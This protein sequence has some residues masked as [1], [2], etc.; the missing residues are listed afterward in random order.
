VLMPLAWRFL[1]ESR[2][3]A[4][5][6]DV[7]GVMTASLG[8]LGIVLGLVRGPDGWTSP[9]VVASLLAGVAILGCFVWWE[10][11]T[12][13][14][15]LPLR[16]FRRRG[17]AA[18]NVS[19]LFFS[20]GMFGSIFFLSQF[21]QTVQG[22]S[23]LGA[24]L[25]ILPWTMAP[26]L[27]A[28]VVGQLAERWGGKLL[29]GVGLALQS[30]ALV[31][32]AA[33]TTP[34]TSYLAFVAPFVVAGVG[35]TLFFVPIASLALGSVPAELEGVASGT[36]AAFRE[37]GGVLGIAVLGAV[38]SSSG[39]YGSRLDYVHGLKPAILVGAT[40]VLLGTLTA[41]LIPAVRRARTQ[42]HTEE[43]AADPL[44][45]LTAA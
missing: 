23:P 22:Y 42:V 38:F 9:G 4:S 12:S 31:W 15:M 13:E 21:L 33:T 37:L 18:I 45:E 19:A 40:V 34:T 44:L 39:S 6:L 7:V 11:R 5:R 16:L 25:R 28:P 32:L 43:S 3:R 10:L 41:L 17:F 27:L 20:F 29:V 8:L 35:M 26:M 1:S 30:V 14:P 2:G 24:G 36:N